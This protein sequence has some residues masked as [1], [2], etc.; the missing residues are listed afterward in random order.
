MTCLGTM[1]KEVTYVNTGRASLQWTDAFDT[2][3]RN[4]ANI[5]HWMTIKMRAYFQKNICEFVFSCTTIRGLRV[6][7][8][9][10]IV[11]H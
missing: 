10:V 6:P 5:E 8:V 9:D 2:R 11:K 3:L 7:E 1:Y 4:V